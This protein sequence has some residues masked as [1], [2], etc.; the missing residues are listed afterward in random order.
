M[1]Q[2]EPGWA[3]DSTHSSCQPAQPPIFP[4]PGLLHCSA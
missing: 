1:V 3:V 4:Q 2:G